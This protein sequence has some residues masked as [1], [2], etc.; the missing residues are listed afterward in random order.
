MLLFVVVLESVVNVI[1]DIEVLF[2]DVVNYGSDDELF[3][4]SYL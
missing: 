4:V 2:D 1:V 3:I